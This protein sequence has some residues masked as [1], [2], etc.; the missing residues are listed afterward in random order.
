MAGV[1]MKNNNENGFTL[2]ELLVV[3]LII[4]ILASIALPQYRAAV[5]RAQYVKLINLVD[6]LQKSAKRYRL[7]AGEYPTSFEDLDT[8]FPGNI[9]FDYKTS[10]YHYRYYDGFPNTG[11]NLM[12]NKAGS[13][14]ATNQRNAYVVFAEDANISDAALRGKV[15]CYAS[16]TDKASQTVCKRETG[17]SSPDRTTSSTAASSWGNLAGSGKSIYV[18]FYN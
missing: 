10:T 3:V 1:Y 13:W 7:A 18:Y 16:S 4:G 6:P 11:N 5:Y 8:D 2:I 15:M 12:V 17:K 9:T 14:Y